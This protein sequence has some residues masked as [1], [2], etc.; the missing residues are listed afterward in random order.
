MR[1]HLY[2]K[3]NG[4]EKNAEELREIADTHFG[5]DMVDNE[6]TKVLMGG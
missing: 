1:A 5:A 6:R 3:G 4:E 2:L